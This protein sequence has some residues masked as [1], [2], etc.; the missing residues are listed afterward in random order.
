MK[1]I[2]SISSLLL[3]TTVMNAQ[4]DHTLHLVE[5]ISNATVEVRG[6]LED[7]QLMEDLSW[8]WS[9]SN[10]CFPATQSQKFT[11]NHVL[12]LTQLPPYSEMEVTVIP[13]DPKDDFSI[14]AYEVGAGREPSVVPNLPSC[15]RCEADH[16]W[17]RQWVGKTQDHTRT[18]KDLVAIKNPYQVV[19]GVVGSQGLQTGGYTL[20]FTLKSR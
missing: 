20:K 12:Y 15:V 9:S 1:N 8:A 18:V 16:K 6:Q 5:C 10:A 2:L 11:G 13:D 7:G 14:Y 3:L 4:N 17:D 19:V